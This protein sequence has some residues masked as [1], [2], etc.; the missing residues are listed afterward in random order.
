MFNWNQTPYICS[1]LS[2]CLS[3]EFSWC[4]LLA[5]MLNCYV[6]YEYVCLYIESDTFFNSL[7][8]RSKPSLC[9]SCKPF[10]GGCSFLLYFPICSEYIRRS[11]TFYLIL[12]NPLFSLFLIPCLYYPPLFIHTRSLL[13]VLSLSIFP[14]LI[15]SSSCSSL[16]FK[17]PSSITQASSC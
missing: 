16:D 11:N 13:S 10:P 17:P 9:L 3:C 7:Y 8:M 1:K 4:L 12:F 15:N 14:F 5:S 2:L 6:V